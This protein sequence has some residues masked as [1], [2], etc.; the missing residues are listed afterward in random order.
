MANRRRTIGHVPN[1][2]NGSV[3][4]S[5]S[6]FYQNQRMIDGDRFWLYVR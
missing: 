3:G 6:R 5:L 4:G 1:R 2:Q